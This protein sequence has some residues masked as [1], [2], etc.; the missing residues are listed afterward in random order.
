M[1]WPWKHET[2][3]N[4]RELAQAR[5]QFETNRAAAGR[6]TWRLAMAVGAEQAEIR[7]NHL[8]ELLHSA[9][10]APRRR[11]PPHDSR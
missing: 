7:R 4:P 8:G 9:L 3:T 1:R 6:A 10:T 5:E 2:E 11:H